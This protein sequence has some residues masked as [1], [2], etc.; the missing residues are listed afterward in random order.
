M[1]HTTSRAFFPIGKDSSSRKLLL[2]KK[3]N[4]FV[5][6]EEGQVQQFSSKVPTVSGRWTKPVVQGQ[7]ILFS[8]NNTSTPLRGSAGIT[9]PA[10]SSRQA[11]AENCSQRSH[12]I[13][14]HYED[15]SQ[16]KLL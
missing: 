2:G 4:A 7:R 5:S 14:V 8:P 9:T 1:L 10:T 11:S 13:I 12:V 6:K 16:Q 3:K 15:Q